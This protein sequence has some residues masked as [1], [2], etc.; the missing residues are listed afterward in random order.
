MADLRYT[1]D[2]NTRRGVQ[3]LRNLNQNVTQTQQAFAGLQRAIGALAIGA[4]VTSSL[5]MANAMTDLSASTN[6]SIQSILGFNQAVRE[7]GGSVEQANRALDG[8][9]RRIGEAAQGSAPLQAA[10]D[11]VGVSLQ[12]LATL[13]EE[14]ILR[15]TVEGL[16]NIENASER[17]SLSQRLFGQAV[18]GVDLA[19]VNAQLEQNIAAASENA[20]AVEAAG[21][22]NQ[23][24]TN[25]INELRIQLLAALEPISQVAAALDRIPGPLLE[26]IKII[27]QIAAFA[28]IWFAVAK[29]IGLALGL[30]FAV[31]KGVAAL[32]TVAATAGRTIANLGNILKILVP[33]G[34]IGSLKTLRIVLAEGVKWARENVKVFAALAGALTTASIALRNFFRRNR[35]EAEDAQEAVD[36]YA[37]SFNRAGEAAEEQARQ[38]VD[39]LQ[40]QVRGIQNIGEAYRQNNIEFRRQFELQTQLIN[41]TDD[42]RIRVQTLAQIEEDYLRTVQQLTQQYADTVRDTT[43]EESQREAL[44][45]ALRD[46]I[47]DV[48]EQYKLQIPVVEELIRARQRELQI[49]QAVAEAQR[50]IEQFEQNRVRAQ[51][52]INRTVLR[53]LRDYQREVDSATLDGLTGIQRELKAIELQERRIAQAARDR[54]R[55][56][57]ADDPEE[58]ERLSE[59]LNAATEE[60]IQRRQALAEQ[61]YRD[62]RT[63][64]RGWRD[65]FRQYRDEATNAARAAE[66]IFTTTT[67]SLEDAIVNFTRTGK[68]EFRGLVNTILEELL[69]LQIRRTVAGIFGSLGGGDGSNSLFGGFFAT[70]GMIPAGRFGVVGERGPELVEGPAS[71]TPMQPTN[72]TYNINAVDAVS[73]KQMVARDPQFLFAVT[74]QGRKRLPGGRS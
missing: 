36:E 44:L 68:F 74:E 26:I 60:L 22:A 43:I 48:T 42:Q 35:E 18:R 63:F 51:E 73:F 56:Q 31:G 1:V 7:N 49:Q 8:L 61:V 4:F 70:G 37:E 65:A 30:I 54:L 71:V 5:R 27:T 45:Q 15:R 21:R 20:R 66:R 50:Q 12:D 28:A 40:R 19:G 10:F 14:D 55:E 47:A 41:L 6:V 33:A 29:G 67:R 64:A 25:A 69:R 53:G 39:A 2:V 58:F 24:F 13:S 72:V 3:N 16:G 9:V 11:R 17:A 46:T 57:L 59:Q 32:G 62:Q 23:N 52:Q 34:L 38:V